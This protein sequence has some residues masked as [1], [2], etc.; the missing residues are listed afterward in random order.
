MKKLITLMLFLLFIVSG[1]GTK[2]S[3]GDVSKIS[4]DMTQ[5]K[6]ED[7]LGSPEVKTTDRE[8]LSTKYDSLSTLYA[9]QIEFDS[10][11]SNKNRGYDEYSDT[12]TAINNKENVELYVYDTSDKNEKI[13]IYFINE[14][15]S[16]FYSLSTD[17]K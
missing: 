10:S 1:C 4:I 9:S 5:S 15:V 6:V 16:F 7:I 2:V 11:E 17:S 8:E 3:A 13:Y 14:K 12:F